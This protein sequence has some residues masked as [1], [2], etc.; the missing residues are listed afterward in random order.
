MNSI[1]RFRLSILAVVSL[2][3]LGTLGFHVIEGWSIVNSLYMTVLVL[4]T[5]GFRE[6]APL[7]LYGKAFTIVL[8]LV[9]I[10]VI[11]IAF[12]IIVEVV[13]SEGVR[14]TWR[15]K[16]MHRQIAAMRNHYIVCGFGRMGQQIAKDFVAAKAPFVVVECNPEQLPRLEEHDIPHVEGD[17]SDDEV[18]LAAGIKHAK[19]LIA[20]APTDADNIYISLSARTLNPKLYIVARSTHEETQ[21]KLYR[22]GAD[23][24]ISPYVIGGRRMAAAILRPNIIDLMDTHV[25]REHL[26]LQLSEL[27]VQSGSS[28]A[29]KTLKESRVKSVTGV[30]VLAVK[31]NGGYK[32]APDADMPLEAGY[33]LI[34]AGTPANVEKLKQLCQSP[35]L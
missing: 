30:M 18:L 19:G 29:G 14:N 4:T 26:E 27:T 6:V 15:K 10:S 13:V 1:S 8:A 24:V 5:I 22:A 7:S 21:D 32:V 28:L 17:A 23:E 16:K 11:F 12:A 34:A 25:A 35:Q 31:T 33:V 3:V 2:L 20:V 9:G